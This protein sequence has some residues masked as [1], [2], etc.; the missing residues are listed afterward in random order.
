MTEKADTTALEAAIGEAD[1]LN[2][3]DYTP[4][5]WAGLG[6]PLADAKAVLADPEATQDEVDAAA[7]ALNDAID[8]L[9]EKADT[10]VLEALVETAGKEDLTQYT[11]KSASAIGKALADAKAVLADPDASQDMVDT[12]YDA[13]Q[14]ALNAAEKKPAVDPEDPEKPEKPAPDTG[15]YTPILVPVI[16]TLVAVILAAGIYLFVR[17]GKKKND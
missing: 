17:H 11:E 13:L 12:A 9:A 10:S 6:E 14:N 2:E 16:F 5:T 4:S 1:A 15:D 7:A 8:A 3:D